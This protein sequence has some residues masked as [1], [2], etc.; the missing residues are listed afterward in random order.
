M[1]RPALALQSEGMQ[2]D[3]DLM[4]LVED[5]VRKI[6]E[7]PPEAREGTPSRDHGAGR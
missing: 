4:G 5:R 1:S 3:E 6:H 2:D 7:Q